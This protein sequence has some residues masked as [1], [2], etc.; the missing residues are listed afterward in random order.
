MKKNILSNVEIIRRLLQKS[1]DSTP[2]RVAVFFKKGAGGYAE[3]DQFMGVTVP[4]LRKI[5]REFSSIQCDELSLLICSPLN[6]ERLL[7]LIILTY[8]YK[9]SSLEI[10]EKLYKFY[11]QNLQHV[12]NWNLVDTSAHL[13]V[14]A[15]LWNKDRSY[16]TTLAI[17]ESIWERRIAIVSTRYFIREGDLEWTF[18]IAS[19]LQKDPQ[20]LIHKAV[21]WMLREA[22]KKDQSQLVNFL[23]NYGSQM[24]RTMLRYAIEKFPEEQRKAYLLRRV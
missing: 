12:N 24:P 11:I 9:S 5:A 22:G 2:D 17:S 21:G 20:D 15:H 16:L 19:I 18:N 1:V 10:K 13:I 14:G 7:A 3:H 8:Q 23:G 6:E 4:T